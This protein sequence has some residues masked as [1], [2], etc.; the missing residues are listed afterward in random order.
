MDDQ[1]LPCLYNVP[2]HFSCVQLLETLW[3]TAHQVPLSVGF[4]R[5]EYRSGLPCPPPGDLPDPGIQ[6]GSLPLVPPGKPFTTPGISPNI[7]HEK[8]NQDKCNNILE[9]S[10]APHKSEQE[11]E[12]SGLDQNQSQGGYSEIFFWFTSLCMIDS[13]SLRVTINDPIAFLFMAEQ[14]SIVLYIL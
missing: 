8:V 3:T 11:A 6:S 2:S 4:S 14:Y 10:S 1:L 9:A 12:S 13:R 7:L 5:Q